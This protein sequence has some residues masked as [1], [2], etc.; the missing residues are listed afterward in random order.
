MQPHPLFHEDRGSDRSL[1]AEDAEQQVLGA[2]VVV[3][4][5]IGFFGGKLQHALGFRAERDFDRR[6]DLL[7]KDRAAFDFLADTFKGEMRARKD[8][9]RQPLAFTYQSEE[10]MLGLNGDAAELAGLIAGKEENPSRPFRIA[11]EHPACL[12]FKT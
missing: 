2:D 10:Q 5:P 7:A 6:R 1:F 8:S 4:Q 3:Q 11:F 9:A 12:G